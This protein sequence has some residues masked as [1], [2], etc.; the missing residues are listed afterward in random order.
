MVALSY[1]IERL[2]Q[3]G[4]TK[5]KTSMS[6]LENTNS[7]EKESCS[8]LSSNWSG[9]VVGELFHRLQKVSIQGCLE[10]L[11]RTARAIT[12]HLREDLGECI[13][14]IHTHL[15]RHCP[16]LRSFQLREVFFFKTKF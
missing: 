13:R 8:M 14:Q 11:S 10:L 4:N 16:G 1:L 6:V 7:L 12:R 2:G 5:K 15:R 9:P 3:S